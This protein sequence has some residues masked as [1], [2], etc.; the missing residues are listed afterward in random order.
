MKDGIPFVKSISIFGFSLMHFSSKV[1]ILKTA[2]LVSPF[3]IGKAFL[4]SL[5]MKM[6]LPKNSICF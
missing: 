4:S 5:L 6:N 2:N 3:F 1:G